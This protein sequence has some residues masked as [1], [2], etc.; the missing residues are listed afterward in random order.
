[1]KHDYI[2]ATLLYGYSGDFAV[3]P[4]F[5]INESMEVDF[6]VMTLGTV[7]GFRFFQLGST[8]LVGN[9]KDDANLEVLRLVN[10]IKQ[11][12]ANPSLRRLVALRIGRHPFIECAEEEHPHYSARGMLFLGRRVEYQGEWGAFRGLSDRYSEIIEIAS[13][14]RILDNLRRV[15]SPR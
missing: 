13:Y 8:V 6:V 4:R 2:V 1:L 5:F 12:R 3:V 14:D 10:L 11:W 15:F 7:P 9:T